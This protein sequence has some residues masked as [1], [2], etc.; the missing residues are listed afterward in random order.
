MIEML[1]YDLVNAV[2]ENSW[3]VYLDRLYKFLTL[4][5]MKTPAA[6]ILS[7]QKKSERKPTPKRHN[8][9]YVCLSVQPVSS[10]FVF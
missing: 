6:K 2:L 1:A 8:L 7:Q 9:S 3:S 4:I 5:A 10:C